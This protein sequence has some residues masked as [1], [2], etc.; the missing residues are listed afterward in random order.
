MCL[1][2]KIM[3]HCKCFDFYLLTSYTSGRF[4][5][6]GWIFSKSDFLV[7]FNIVNNNYITIA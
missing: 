5:Y 2:E 1:T 7:N 4:R 6:I 3:T